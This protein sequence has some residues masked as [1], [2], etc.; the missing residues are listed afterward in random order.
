MQEKTIDQ[1]APYNRGPLGD[2]S[3][4][5]LRILIR[6]LDEKIM[7]W[8]VTVSRGVYSDSVEEGLLLWSSSMVIL[9]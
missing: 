2:V 8:K 6:L 9:L 4:L 1:K 5:C 7:V 3:S